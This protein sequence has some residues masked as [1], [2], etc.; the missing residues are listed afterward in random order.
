MLILAAALAFAVAGC[1]RA[2]RRPDAP[3]VAYT[4]LDG[5]K[6][7]STEQWRGKVVLVNF[8]ATT[9]AVCVKE[10]PALVATH[11]KYRGATFDTVAVAMKHDPPASV[12]RFA[13]SRALPFG[14]AI[15]NTGEIARAFGNVHITPTTYL[16]DKRGRIVKRFRGEPD[17]AELHRLIEALV[18]ET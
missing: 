12:V 17:L 18:A 3:E 10:M 9:C 4:L 6:V 14:V 2:D 15:D 5:A 1:D 16:I 8:W 11:Q 13:H 7:R